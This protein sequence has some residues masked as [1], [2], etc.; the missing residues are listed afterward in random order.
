MGVDIRI[1]RARVDMLIHR[2][3]KLTRDYGGLESGGLNRL[4][5]GQ[6][7]SDEDI[8]FAIQDAITTFNATGHITHY[9]IVTFPEVGVAILLRGIVATVLESIHL[10][11]MRNYA[12]F[13]DG[14]T[15][16]SS[17]SRVPMLASTV[18]MLRADVERRTISLKSAINIEEALGSVA[19]ASSEYAWINDVFSAPYTQWGGSFSSRA[20]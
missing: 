9:N 12:S 18:G 11:G 3:R 19:G 16:F 17:E 6:E 20:V 13:S 4:I 10:L 5:D 15:T 7:S 1:A 8:A 14:G 2:Y